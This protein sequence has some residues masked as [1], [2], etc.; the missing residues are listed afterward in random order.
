MKDVQP[1]DFCVT[2]D[3]ALGQ[4][5]LE[6]T[7]IKH[8]LCCLTLWHLGGFRD[9]RKKMPE[10]TWLCTGISPLLYGLRTWSKRQKTWQ[11]F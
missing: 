8:P 7:A 10:R 5:G 2:T 1:S 4:K 3:V 9:F 6:T 11:V